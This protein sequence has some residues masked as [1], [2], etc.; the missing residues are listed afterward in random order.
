MS[1]GATGR[2]TA[3]A[4]VAFRRARELG[5]RCVSE[6]AAPAHAARGV[7]SHPRCLQDGRSLARAGDIDVMKARF[8]HMRDVL[9]SADVVLAPSQ[10]IAD[11][12]A[13]CGMADRDVRRWDLGIQ[14]TPVKR[15]VRDSVSPLRV[16]FVGS[17]IPTKAP[18]L[19]IEAA[20]MLPRGIRDGRSGRRDRQLP[21]R[22]LVSR[23]SWRRCFLIR[24]SVVMVPFHTIGCPNI[25]AAWT[26]SSCRRSGWRT[27]RSSSRKRSPRGSRSSP[28]TLEECGEGARR[29]GRPSV[30]ARQRSRV[31]VRSCGGWTVT[32]LLVRLRRHPAAETI[33]QDAAALRQPLLE[34]IS[35]RKDASRSPD[36]RLQDKWLGPQDR[37]G[38]RV[39]LPD[40]GADMAR[41]SLPADLVLLR[42]ARFWSSTTA[43][44]T[45][46][47]T[48]LRRLRRACGAVPASA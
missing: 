31:G 1:G 5:R 28:Q 48:A 35:N 40:A 6:R 21:R 41:G 2:L 32:G 44:R 39:E 23:T 36:F 47:R 10:T 15:T 22:R 16:G 30:R 43:L 27:R 19:L 38:R 18:H 24:L 42:R 29:G 12:F 37:H 17:F 20:R 3:S 11:R 14:F 26:F 33:E 45:L 34:L 9:S 8:S 4:A 46:R 7:R 13:A 25:S